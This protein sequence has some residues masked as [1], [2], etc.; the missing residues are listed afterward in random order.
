VFKHGDVVGHTA[1]RGWVGVVNADVDDRIGRVSVLWFSGEA[2]ETISWIEP[3]SEMLYKV[4]GYEFE[5]A[6]ALGNKSEM[7][8]LYYLERDKANRGNR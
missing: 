1:I 4:D 3:S 7:L 5:A 6:L 8:R 2:A